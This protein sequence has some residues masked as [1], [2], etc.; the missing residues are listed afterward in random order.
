MQGVAKEVLLILPKEETLNKY[1]ELY[2]IK[3]RRAVSNLIKYFN[4]IDTEVF[5]FS[6][7]DVAIQNKDLGMKFKHSLA[8]ED[9]YYLKKAVDGEAFIE[10]AEDINEEHYIKARKKFPTPK[11]ISLDDRFQIVIKRDKLAGNE[12]IK[13]NKV[14]I[15]MEKKSNAYYKVEPTMQNKRIIPDK[16]IIFKIDYTNFFMTA[17]LSGTP[18][19][20]RYLLKN[21]NLLTSVDEWKIEEE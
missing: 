18:I 20:I 19:D 6:S 4:S 2:F 7:D 13:T 12:Y 14:T 11:G 15:T 3:F 10:D 9:R 17:T 16:R 5:C 21:D 1:D 8:P